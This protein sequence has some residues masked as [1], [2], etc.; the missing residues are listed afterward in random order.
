MMMSPVVVGLFWELLYSPSWGSSTTPWGLVILP[1]SPTRTWR[2]T[3]S[4]SPT[5]GLVALRDAVVPGGLSAIPQHL[6]EAAAIDRAG[7]GSPSR[8]SRYRW[9]RHCC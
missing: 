3:Q 2:F 7:R 9:W 5:S 8:G 4:P 1:G 6:Y